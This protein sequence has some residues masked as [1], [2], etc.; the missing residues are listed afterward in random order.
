MANENHCLAVQE[1]NLVMFSDKNF[2]ECLVRISHM[3]SLASLIGEKMSKPLVCWLPEKEVG[4][5]VD[6]NIAEADQ[7]I[8]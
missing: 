8:V 7:I 3:P 2:G 4:R 5:R 1:K 6:Q